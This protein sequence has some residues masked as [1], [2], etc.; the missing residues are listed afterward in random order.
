MPKQIESAPRPLSTIA[1]PVI[2]NWQPEDSH[3][4]GRVVS[5]IPPV[6]LLALLLVNCSG[7]PSDSLLLTADMPLHLED[8]LD[9][10]I[11]VGSEAP[12][13]VREPVGWGAEQL[14]SDWRGAYSF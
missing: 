10:A 5:R 9:A 14:R 11:V 1:Q 4:F 2:P 3:G 12:E 13:D 8:H 7:L 6:A